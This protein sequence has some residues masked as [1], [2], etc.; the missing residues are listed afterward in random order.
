MAGLVVDGG[1]EFC[2]SPDGFTAIGSGVDDDSLDGLPVLATTC[3]PAGLL[4]GRDA[5]ASGFERAAS[6]FAGKA[7]GFFDETGALSE[8]ASVPTGSERELDTIC[9]FRT[10]VAL[11]IAGSAA[12][13]TGFV[14]PAVGAGGLTGASGLGRGMTGLSCPTGETMTTGGSL[15][16]R[17]TI[18]AG[19]LGLE[20]ET[21][22]KARRKAARPHFD[23]LKMSRPTQ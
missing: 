2:G 1:S 5:P 13:V 11:A 10:G 16:D 3:G 6:G 18:G 4:L 8:R 14:G 17:S 9:G 22:P 19:F 12:G 21:R 23:D 7:S 15:L 20:Q